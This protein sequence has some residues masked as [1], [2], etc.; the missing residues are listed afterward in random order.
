[1]SSFMERGESVKD[2]VSRLIIDFM[3]SR[4]ECRENG[5]GLKQA[6]IFRGCGL[7]WG[8]QQ[9]ATSSNQQY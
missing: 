1:M 6:E 5:S 3:Q 8:A 4:S 7:Y 9:N 2:V